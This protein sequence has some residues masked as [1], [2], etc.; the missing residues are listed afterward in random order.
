MTDRLPLSALSRRSFL[1]S[2]AL[3]T[4]AAIATV[5]CS[6]RS[7][8]S[9]GNSQSRPLRIGMN[10][11]A[12][13]M[14]WKVAQ[15]KDFF[16]AHG[17]N[18]EV[19]WFPVLSDQL[20]AFNA[21]KVDVA[22]M[23]MSDMLTGLAGGLQTKIVAI[24]D[25]S[26]GADAILVS[27]AINSMQDLVGKR[28]SIEIG[29]VGH[30]LFLKALEQ[31]GVSA[32][33]VEIVNQS[34]DAATAALIAG[35][36]DCAYSYEPFVSQAVQSG[37]GKVIFSSKDIPG[38]IPDPLVVHDQVLSEQPEAIQALMTVWYETLN[39][40]KTHLDEVLPIEAKQAGVSLEEYNTILKGFS[41]LTP[42]ECL[43]AF[44]PGDSMESVLY[45]SQVI[46]D[47]MLQ[48]DLI[49]RKPD[50]IEPYIDRGFVE[51]YLKG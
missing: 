19:I 12:G 43:K 17:I 42:E 39:Y 35:K 36:T 33:Q 6:D 40:R 7:T 9:S 50:S 15:E 20:T 23:T 31:G 3:S 8:N 21:G 29:T 1:R 13:F 48:Q 46:G 10:L 22:G 11:W 30:M 26:L 28:A 41:W 27:P 49:T 14:P 2:A 32:D 4:M 34:A 5:S 38:I 24:T 25:I 44:E 37:Q 18:A 51:Q 16:T 45:S 47:F